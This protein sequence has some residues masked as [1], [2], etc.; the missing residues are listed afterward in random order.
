MELRKVTTR[1]AASSS[2]LKCHDE[3]IGTFAVG[4][5][6][7]TVLAP[8]AAAAASGIS[9]S[10]HAQPGALPTNVPTVVSP[11]PKPEV[12]PDEI[13][14]PAPRRDQGCLVEGQV[15][16]RGQPG[17]IRGAGGQAGY[18]FGHECEANAD[19]SELSDAS[20]RGQPRYGFLLP[21]CGDQAVPADRGAACCAGQ[22]HEHQRPHED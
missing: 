2:T 5:R 1:A 8:A 19:D 22:G 12:A 13:T 16:E 18:H 10:S 11:P 3:A 21:S 7:R 6:R 17:A 15:C 14:A 20:R 9:I 4:G